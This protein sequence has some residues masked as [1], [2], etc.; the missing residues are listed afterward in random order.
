MDGWEDEAVHLLQSIF[1]NADPGYLQHAVHNSPRLSSSVTQ[2]AAS[3]APPVP[4]LSAFFGVQKRDKGKNKQLSPHMELR[5][6][7]IN[8]TVTTISEKIL[9]INRGQYPQAAWKSVPRHEVAEV[10]AA[11]SSRDKRTTSALESAEVKRTWS[12]ARKSSGIPSPIQPMKK[13][14]D[15]TLMKNQALVQLH[16]LV[17]TRPIAEIRQVIDKYD[18]SYLF[19]AADEVLR[20]EEQYPRQSIHSWFPNPFQWGTPDDP[21]KTAPPVLTPQDL[22]RSPEYTN[23]ILSHLKTIFPRVPDS[24]IRSI[25][26][27][28]GSY[29]T[30]RSAT[31]TWRLRQGRI[32]AWIA[33]HFTPTSSSLNPQPMASS[34]NVPADFTTCDELRN[35]IWLFDESRRAEQAA[36]DEK[37]ARLLNQEWTDSAQLF[38]CGCCFDDVPFEDVGCCA[39]GEHL[40]CARCIRMQ[41]EQHVY[42]GVPLRLYNPDKDGEEVRPGEGTGVRCLSIEGCQSPFSVRELE[43]L[44]TP[45]MFAALSRRLGESS[46][47]RLM[48]EPTSILERVIRCPFCPY[49]EIED[50]RVISRAFPLIMMRPEDLRHRDF[51]YWVFMTLLGF[52]VVPMLYITI[53][54]AVFFFPQTFINHIGSEPPATESPSDKNSSISSNPHR[55]YILYPLTEPERVLFLTHHFISNIGRKVIVARNGGRP[56]FQCRNGPNGVPLPAFGLTV[57]QS[58]SHTDLIRRVWGEKALRNPRGANEE[59]QGSCGRQ[60]CVNCQRVYVDGLHRCFEDEKEG[61]RL[62]VEKAMS[63][64]VKRTCPHCGVSITKEAGCNKVVCRCGYAMCFICRSKIGKEGYAHFCGHFRAGAGLACRDCDK[65]NLWEGIDEKKAAEKAAEEARAHWA[66]EHPTTGVG[67]VHHHTIGPKPWSEKFVERV[68]SACE[69]ILETI[70]S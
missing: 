41:V 21:V 52:G 59:Q 23:A 56:V 69:T 40:F 43:R 49:S 13:V 17:P 11:S 61:L 70:L 47:E 19:Q 34:S 6:Q 16:C 5:A 66:R 27:D 32:K 44:L 24:A 3:P 36:E 60:S 65:C 38:T 62:A 14:L 7:Q 35:E 10:G 50:A 30:M 12:H 51:S 64:A 33:D 22:Y 25:V 8:S 15:R 37:L 55:P 42:G 46:L 48:V 2:T 31:E 29:S 1:P 45:E 54:W 58:T 26:L 63:D 67:V 39:A 9:E 57:E 68:D 53:F 18:H 4:P 20:L 28:G